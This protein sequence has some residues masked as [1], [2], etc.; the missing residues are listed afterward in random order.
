MHLT[1]YPSPARDRIDESLSRDMDAVLEVVGAGHAARQEAAIKVRQPLPAL[2]VH[3]REPAMLA[4]V[5]RLQDQV[6]D[7]LNVKSLQPIDRS[8]PVRRRTPIRPN[9]RAL[10]PRLGKQSMPSATPLP[11]WIQVKW[12]HLSEPGVT[13]NSI[14]QRA[15]LR[16][17]Q[18]TFWSTG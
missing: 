3:T 1:D 4:S 16:S 18:A 11:R 5:L 12:Q 10:G 7:E 15:E 2:L 17:N 6:L 8:R 9:L 14:R 13:S